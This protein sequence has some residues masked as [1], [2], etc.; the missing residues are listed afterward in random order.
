[1]RGQSQFRTIFLLLTVGIHEPGLKSSERV[2]LKDIFK[3]GQSFF[4]IYV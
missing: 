2:G 4:K 3:G 1:L